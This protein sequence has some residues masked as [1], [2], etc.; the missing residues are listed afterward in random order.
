MVS[1]RFRHSYIQRLL[2]ALIS[3]LIINVAAP[4]DARVGE[5]GAFGAATHLMGPA[6]WLATGRAVGAD[7]I[8]RMYQNPAGL[9]GQSGWA[10]SATYSRPYAE[11]D[12]LDLGSLDV[13][14]VYRGWNIGASYNHLAVTG[15]REATS[16]GTLS[17][18]TFS[19]KHQVAS[20]AFARPW[21]ERFGYGVQLHYQDLSV[22]SRSKSRGT[23]DLGGLYSTDRFRAL[24]SVRHLTSARGGA[25]ELPIE[26][27][28]RVEWR[29]YSQIAVGA[30]LATSEGDGYNYNAGLQ[31]NFWGP[32]SFLAGYAHE[33]EQWSGGLML[34]HGPINLQYAVMFHH[35]L[36]A[37]HFATLG[38]EF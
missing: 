27:E 3:A 19:S 29:P 23:I 2:F 7:T 14:G 6:G 15:I 16:A 11:I 5:G 32:I 13:A 22:G 26:G 37:S 9:A 12:G 34:R 18:A 20:V 35:E 4:A 30:A 36:E 1:T 24:L 8:A 28:A 33:S 21:R 25:D 31:Y 10:A 38:V 17:G